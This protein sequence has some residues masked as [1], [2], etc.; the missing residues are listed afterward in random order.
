M[1]SNKRITTVGF[2]FDHLKSVEEFC[3]ACKLVGYKNNDSVKSMRLDWCLKLGG[4]FFLTY[5]DGKLISLS[6]CHPL[7]EAGENI[8]RILFR[9]ATLPG[10]QNLHGTLSKTHM[11]SIPFYYH[12]PRQVNWANTLGHNT[13]A[14]TTNHSNKDSIQSM[15]KSHRVLGLLEKQNLVT[16][17]QHDLWLFNNVQSV[18]SLNL[19]T[20]FTARNNF[21]ERNALNI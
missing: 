7:P 18:W 6:G 1:E 15:S 2:T 8:Y 13:Y 21:K 5:F 14:I 9:G 11:N 16:C 12:V 4:Q 19:D 10:Y 3:Q 17:L 20:Y